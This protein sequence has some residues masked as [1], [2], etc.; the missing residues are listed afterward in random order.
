MS[1]HHCGD[2]G[3]QAADFIDAALG[4]RYLVDFISNPMVAST[5]E[6]GSTERTCLK[7]RRNLEGE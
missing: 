2:S 5:D 3:L 6:R 7:P 4:L 1:P